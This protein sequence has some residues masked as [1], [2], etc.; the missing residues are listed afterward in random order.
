MG[1]DEGRDQLGS[2]QGRRRF[3]KVI[4]STGMV[5][6]AGCSGNSTNQVKMGT[7]NDSRTITTV[8]DDKIVTTETATNTNPESESDEIN[9]IETD[10]EAKSNN[11]LYQGTTPRL[12]EASNHV[13]A[14]SLDRGD[15]AAAPDGWRR[16]FTVGFDPKDDKSLIF[17]ELV[18]DSRNSSDREVIKTEYLGT[19]VG[20]EVIFSDPEVDLGYKAV[21][22]E[23][24]EGSE[25]LIAGKVRITI[26][27]Q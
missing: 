26:F 25:G 24:D 11:I 12:K 15:Y 2:K 17:M 10:T 1:L 22:I 4:G 13:A 8:A 7:Q 20:S 9:T 19:E 21:L 14:F 27:K 18:D 16:D 6:L 23:A 3:L 5:A